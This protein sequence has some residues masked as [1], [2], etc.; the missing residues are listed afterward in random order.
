MEEVIKDFGFPVAYKSPPRGLIQ[1][2]L[3]SDQVQLLH[4]TDIIAE[5]IVVL[6][7]GGQS[8]ERSSREGSKMQWTFAG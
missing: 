8:L 2:V 3:K 5:I 7:T 1:S 4:D 6:I